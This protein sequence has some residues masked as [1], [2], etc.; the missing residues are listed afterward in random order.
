M[1][2]QELLRHVLTIEPA[3]KDGSFVTFRAGGLGTVE[4]AAIEAQLRQLGAVW[5]QVRTR[6]G[7]F[8]DRLA[9]KAIFSE[10]P[11]VLRAEQ[12]ADATA[13]GKGVLRS[14]PVTDPGRPA[15]RSRCFPAPRSHYSGATALDAERGGANPLVLENKKRIRVARPAGPWAEFRPPPNGGKAHGRVGPDLPGENPCRSAG[16]YRLPLSGR[17]WC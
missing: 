13:S 11:E 15:R 2:K 7:G 12:A 14:R 5:V 6:E 16:R 10:T 9:I 8:G 17:A 1:T 3:S 4:P